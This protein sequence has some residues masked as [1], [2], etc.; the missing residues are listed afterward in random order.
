MN[1]ILD[2]ISSMSPLEKEGFVRFIKGRSKRKEGR[3]IE[4]FQRL[5][6]GTEDEMKEKIGTNAFNVLKMRLTDSLIAFLSS[7]VFENEM[8]TEA[9]IIRQI[10]LARKMLQLDK[11]KTGK[12]ILQRIEKTA[13][14]IQHFSLLNEIYHSLIEIS[15]IEE[16]LDQQILFQKL[17]ANTANFLQQERLNL[18]YAQVKRAFSESERGGQRLDLHLLIKSNFEK[19]GISEQRGYGL[20]SLYQLAMVLDYAGAQSRNYHNIDLF[21]IEKIDRLSEEERNNERNHL[22]HIDLL[23]TVANIY[24]RKRNFKQSLLYLERMHHQM[25]R[26]DGKFQRERA[27]KYHL[28]QALNLNYGNRPNEALSVLEKIPL[29]QKDSQ[30]VLQVILTKIMVLAQ[31][32][33]FKEANDLMRDLY[34]SDAYYK[35]VAGLEWVINRR[36]IEIILHIELGNIDFAVSRIESITRQHKDFLSSSE[37]AQAKP[38]LRILKHY[39]N[40]PAAV[41]TQAFQDRVE[42][43]IPWNLS[44]EQDIFFISMYAWLKSKMTRNTIYKT[45]IDL[46]GQGN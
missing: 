44:S 29:K 13:I 32:E 25:Q 16:S 38:F 43:T 24:F 11:V 5:D 10:V 8:T 27:R 23:Y 33:K 17:E 7:N 9:Q 46:L 18:V 30:E 26:F 4:L 20:K 1:V 6:A 45:T 21:L 39:L 37:N 35:R 19:F 34:K 12:K 36:F 42:K 31:Q 3:S 2:L 14:S 22:Y 15:H 28:L 40:N 41:T